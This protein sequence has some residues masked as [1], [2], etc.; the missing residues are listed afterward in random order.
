M[1]EQNKEDLE[2]CFKHYIACLIITTFSQLKNLSHPRN[3]RLNGRAVYFRY[4]KL[5][6]D[7]ILAF[8]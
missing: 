5:S 7:D 4:Y 8:L 2:V 6:L 1:R 3:L